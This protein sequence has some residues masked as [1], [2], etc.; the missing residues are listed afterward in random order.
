MEWGDYVH[1]SLEKRGREGIALPEDMKAFEKYALVIDDMCK[2]EGLEITFEQQMAIDID[3]RETPYFGEAVHGRGKLDVK[4]V[5][6]AMAYIMDWKTGKKREDPLELKLQAVLLKARHPQVRRIVGR[7]IW[8]K[9]DAL[10]QP[11]ELGN[12]G[13]TQVWI[14]ATLA[15]AENSLK[16]NSWA[17]RPSPLC[18]W[19]DVKTCEYNSNR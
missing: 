12:V 2:M 19:C 15:Q 17:K 18:G 4:M 5:K 13:E 6:G 7:Y 8:L 11:Y 16:T 3:C 9:D 10:G 1:K 14:D